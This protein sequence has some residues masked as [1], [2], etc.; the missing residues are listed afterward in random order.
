VEPQKF[1][2]DQVSATRR[3]NDAAP[4]PIIPTVCEYRLVFTVK[5]STINTYC[6]YEL[7][8]GPITVFARKMIQLLAGP[9]P[10]SGYT[11]HGF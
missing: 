7:V 9:E 4:A 1:D 10:G 11:Q 5:H 8:Y 2:A 6:I 3:K